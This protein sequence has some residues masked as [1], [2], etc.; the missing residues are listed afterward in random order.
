MALA[1]DA[2]ADEGESVVSVSLSYATFAIPDH[3]PSGSVVGMDY[4]RG[5]TDVL[6]L[7][8]SGGAGV[9][10]ADSASYSGHGVVGLTYALDVLKYVPYVNL[11]VGGIV[12]T[13]GEF[14][15]EVH[16]LAE[17]GGGL[18]ILHSPNFS[19]GVQA[20]F[21]SF[22]TETAFFSAGVRLSWR[23]GFF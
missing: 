23:W 13:G 19:Y 7:R 12:T 21:E 6:W 16:P 5:I 22:L 17:L 15:T 20:R 1:E 2:L 3:N 14:D 10:Y 11:G 9:Y 8:A 4:E 18:D